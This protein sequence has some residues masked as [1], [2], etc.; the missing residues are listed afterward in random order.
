[1]GKKKWQEINGKPERRVDAFLDHRGWQSSYKWPPM[2][3]VLEPMRGL[4][5]FN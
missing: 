5:T 4:L 3:L 1:M 2:Q